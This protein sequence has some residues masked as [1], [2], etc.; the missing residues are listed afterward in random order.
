MHTRPVRV[1]GSYLSPYVRKVLV[2]LA[3][4]RVPYLI[5]P[6]VPF[7]GDEDFARLSPL[8]R[9]PVLVDDALALAD[10]TVIC[11]YLDDRYPDPP[12]LP[13]D[14]AA[15]ARAR[16]FEEY[17]DSKLG[18]AFIWHLFNQVTIRRFVW[19]EPPDEA[20]LQHARDVEIPQAMDY[21]EGQL[22]AEGWLFGQPGRADVALAAFFRNATWARWRLDAER[23]PR[24]AGFVQR[25]LALPAFEALR[26]FEDLCVRTPIAQHREAL[27]GAGAPLT[28]GSVGNPTPRRGLMSL[29]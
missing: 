22:P 24:A 9:V 8:R 6:I 14:P 25:T 3:L 7:Y 27:L 20:V 28:E 26:P 15:R 1:I 5:D 19:G 18:E 13:A 16:W 4:K 11:E 10:S 17:A 23:W 2:C 29:L 21:L 12:L